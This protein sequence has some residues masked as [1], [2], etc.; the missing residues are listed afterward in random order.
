[1]NFTRPS[2]EELN[3]IEELGNPSWNWDSFFHYMK[4]VPFNRTAVSL[5]MCSQAC[6]VRLCSRSFYP[7]KMLSD[8][9]PS[10]TQLTM[11][12]MVSSTSQSLLPSLI[13]LVGPVS[14]SYSPI[15]AEMHLKLFDAAENLG[16]PRNPQ[17]VIQFHFAMFV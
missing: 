1:M 2:R 11:A 16:I 5:Y 13:T 8:M 14:S 17:A 7:K 3:A 9:L 4:K 6:R 10:R 12:R 15:W